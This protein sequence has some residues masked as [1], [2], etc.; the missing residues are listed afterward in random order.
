MDFKGLLASVTASLLIVFRRFIY[1]IITPYE[2]MRKISL[3]EDHMQ[4]A[5]ILFLAFIYFWVSHI[6]RK[7]SISFILVYLVFLV[8]FIW[9]VLFFFFLGIASTKKVAFKN[10]LFT[11]TYSLFPTLLWFITNSLFYRLLPPPRTI[12]IA[13]RI[14]SIFFISFS[15]SI[16][17]WKIILMY[18]AIRF[19]TKQ[20]FYR[21]IYYLILYLSYLIPFSLISYHFKIFRIPFI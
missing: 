6:I 21:V 16:L 4:V 13:G 5:I 2:T 18:L 15:L 20:N 10:F 12:S 14:F 11:L 9:T 8:N 1:L 19:S 3:E 17:I 7:S